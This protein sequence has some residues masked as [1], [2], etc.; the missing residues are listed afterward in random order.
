M[1]KPSKSGKIFGLQAVKEAVMAGESIDKVLIK[2]GI[3]G[4]LFAELFKILRD[5]K[6]NFQYVPQEKLNK[7]SGGNHQG[8]I[9]LVSPIEFQELEDIIPLLFEQGS[10]PFIVIL[11]EVSDVRNFGAIV[12]TAECSGVHA[13]IVPSKGAAAIG[14][15][16]MKTS[17]GA[18][19]RI[20]VSKS[21]NLLETIKFL[22]ACGLQIIA[23]DEK[24]E[25]SYYDIDFTIPTALIVGSEETGI[26][27]ENLR[28]ADILTKI[29]MMG[30]VQSLNVSVAT[31]IL[32]FE[33]VKQRLKI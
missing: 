5:R 20:P 4:E 2:K 24:A 28:E 16:A 21:Q 7:L 29:P 15:D 6:I 8:I 33:A 10:I 13:I 1:N 19:T 14:A 12:R 26:Q 31:G 27:K 25:R 22:K 11:D 23:A 9:A 30:E 32:L 18:L 17:S 3:Q